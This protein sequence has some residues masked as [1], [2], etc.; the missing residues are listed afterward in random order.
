MSTDALPAQLAETWRIHD[1]INQYL[2]D[3]IQPDAL[4]AI[5]LT[6]GRSVAEQFAH[7]HNVRLMWIKEGAPDLL[8]GLQKLEKGAPTDHAS[9]RAALESSAAAIETMLARALETGKLRGFKPH[10][11]AFLGYLVSHESHHR[12]QIAVAL[13]GAGHPLDKKTAF[14]LWEWGVR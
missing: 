1:R 11:V 8:D 3:A 7:I 6:K 5:G 10:P 4:S 12:G 2:L 13:K 14:G 9:L